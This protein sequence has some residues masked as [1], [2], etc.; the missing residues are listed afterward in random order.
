MALI[1]AI[2]SVI[3]DRLGIALGRPGIGIQIRGQWGRHT[4][5]SVQASPW[6]YIYMANLSGTLAVFPRRATPVPRGCQGKKGGGG[7]RRGPPPRGVRPRRP[8][9]AGR[10]GRGRAGGK[11]HDHD[12]PPHCKEHAHLIHKPTSTQQQ[13]LP[14]IESI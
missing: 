13:V 3:R 2:G 7:D 6:P 10:A 5:R 11:G 4:G 9:R 14:F 1:A 12:H 8:P